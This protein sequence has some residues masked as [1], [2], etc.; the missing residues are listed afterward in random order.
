VEGSVPSKTKEETSKAQP[1][2]NKMIVVHL[3]RLTSY[4]GTN[5]NERPE[6][7]RN[8]SSWRVIITRNEPRGR[9]ARPITDVA[10][11]ALGKEE[12][13]VRQ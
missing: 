5:K 12:M 7:G 6:G 8:R 1:L 3:D 11:T 10:S 2:E 9:K 4:Q 13:A